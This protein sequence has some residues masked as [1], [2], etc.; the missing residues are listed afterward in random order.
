MTPETL[1]DL[2]SSPANPSTPDDGNHAV[3]ALSAAIR[4]TLLLGTCFEAQTGYIGAPV[5][6]LALTDPAEMLLELRQLAEFVD[7]PPLPVPVARDPD[8]DAVLALA[9]ASQ[10]DLIVSAMR[11]PPSPDLAAEGTGTGS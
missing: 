9:T 4:S 3:A 8:D 6:G 5:T 2:P 1:G 11:P 10:A 7:P